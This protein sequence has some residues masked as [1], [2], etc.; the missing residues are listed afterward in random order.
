MPQA[1]RQAALMQTRSHCTARHDPTRPAG[2][3]RLVREAQPMQVQM[4]VAP[5]LFFDGRREEAVA[6]YRE[7]LAPR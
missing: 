6:F 2:G 1:R 7:S 3:V 4:Q 5:Y